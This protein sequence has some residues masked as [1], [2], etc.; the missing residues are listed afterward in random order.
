MLLHGDQGRVGVS[1]VVI[2]SAVT[3]MNCG[4]NSFEFKYKQQCAGWRT[5]LRI[6]ILPDQT[7][8]QGFKGT[9]LFFSSKAD[10]M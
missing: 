9:E 2:R 6:W 10:M 4:P 5:V 7:G 3:V 1:T 8:Q